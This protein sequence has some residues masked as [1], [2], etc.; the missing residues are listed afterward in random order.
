MDGNP[1]LTINK[2]TGQLSVTPTQQ[3]IYAISIRVEEYRNGKKLGEVRRELQL[4]ISSCSDNQSPQYNAGAHN[5]TYYLQ[6]TDTFRLPIQVTDANG[7]SLHLRFSGAIFTE[8]GATLSEAD[9]KAELNSELVWYTNCEDAGDT[10]YVFLVTEDNG[11]PI[12]KKSLSTIQLIVAPPPVP[13]PPDITCLDRL[14]ANTIRINYINAKPDKFFDHYFLIR[15]NPD[16]TQTILDTVARKDIDSSIIDYTAY[17]HSQNF[18]K[19]FFIG[20]NTCGK[21]GDAGYSVS[22]DPDKRVPNQTYIVKTTVINNQHVFLTWD[23]SD[24]EDFKMYRIYRKESGKKNF[25]LYR[26]IN[27]VK[28]TVLIDSS[29][30]VQAKSYCYYITVINSCGTSS[31]PGNQSCSILLL[32]SA[33]PFEHTLDWN[34]YI[35]WKGG[36]LNYSVTRRDPGTDSTQIGTTNTGNTHFFDDKLNIEWGAYWYK[37]VAKEGPGGRG[38]TSESNEI[39]LIQAPMVYPPNAFTPNGDHVNDSFNAMPVFVKDYK[40]K[41]FNRWGEQVFISEDK[42]QLWDGT[43]KGNRQFNNVY[44]YQI[45]YTGWDSSKHWL[46]GNVTTF[47]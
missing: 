30:D 11:C 5:A 12:H 10:Q 4:T 40:L 34:E 16:N 43:F 36:V 46:Q 41:V 28:D 38:A 32:G 35:Q 37:I 22:T 1:K 31:E 3:G 17:N 47:W 8:G 26:E 6:A 25:T 21:P 23:K 2:R 39:N 7:D 19:Y 13:D 24:A 20:Y 33:V 9:G 42:H 14:D 29:V 27:K 44:I 15:K 45:D 18:Y